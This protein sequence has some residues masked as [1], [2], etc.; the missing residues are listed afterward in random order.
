[1]GRGL[2][3]VAALIII[4]GV[5]WMDGAAGDVVTLAAVGMMVL[6]GLAGF[7]MGME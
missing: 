3:L 1:V 6:A 4:C 2:C 7:T 5:M